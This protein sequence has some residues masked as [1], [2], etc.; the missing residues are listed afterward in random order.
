MNSTLFNEWVEEEIKETLE[1]VKRV[2]TIEEYNTLLE[3]AKS[4]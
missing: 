4:I 2:N 1:K 3:K